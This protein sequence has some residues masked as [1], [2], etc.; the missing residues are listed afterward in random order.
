MRF[1]FVSIKSDRLI[2][3]VEATDIEAAG[4]HGPSVHGGVL[5]HIVSEIAGGILAATVL[6][7]VAD[8]VEV[9]LP[10]YI[11]RWDCPVGLGVLR[12]LLHTQD[13]IV[14]V[15][16]YDTCALKLLD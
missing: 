5:D 12:F 8:E 1:V 9:F 4:G 6:H 16:L 2:I 10:I 7:G 3:C 11:E 15:E 14:L 13:T